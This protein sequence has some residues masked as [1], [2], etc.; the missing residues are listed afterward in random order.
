M[1][2][3]ILSLLCLLM[4]C[5][6][7]ASSTVV[8]KDGTTVDGTVMKFGNTYRVKTADGQTKIIPEADVKQVIRGNTKPPGTGTTPTPPPKSDKPVPPPDPSKTVTKTTGGA[9]FSATKAKADGVS[10]TIWEKFIDANP[11]SS[12]LDAAK[13]ELAKW[14]KLQKDEAE[15]INGKW[16]GGE[17]I[18]QVKE[19]ADKLCD[20]GELLDG[21]QT[22]QGL[23]KF[24]DGAEGLPIQLP[25]HF[26]LGYYYLRSRRLNE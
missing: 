8:L 19:K 3:C 2:K 14:Q 11:N 24:E 15:R 26:H 18:K 25:R 9:V 5:A 12:D 20:E 22:V 10:S 17:E 6:V 7:C 21:S 1:S 16:V 13:A 4:A 23:A